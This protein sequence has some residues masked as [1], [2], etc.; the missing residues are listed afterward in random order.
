LVVFEKR[1]VSRLVCLE[2][3]KPKGLLSLFDLLDHKVA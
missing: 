1:H 2:D 3:G